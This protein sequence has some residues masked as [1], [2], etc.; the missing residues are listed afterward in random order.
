MF[1]NSVDEMLAEEAPVPAVL[2]LKGWLLLLS[3]EQPC[4]DHMGSETRGQ[5][6]QRGVSV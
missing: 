3:R 2:S 4:N 1:P 5:G 6:L